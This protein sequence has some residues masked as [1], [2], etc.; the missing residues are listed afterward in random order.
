MAFCGKMIIFVPTSKTIA[1]LDFYMMSQMEEISNEY[2]VY[3]TDLAKINAAQYQGWCIHLICLAGEGSFVYNEKCFHFTSDNILILS[4]P[5]LIKNM[6]VTDDMQVEYLAAP[7]RWLYSQ[8][9]A[10]HYGIGGCIDL[11]SDP[12]VPVSHQEAQRFLGDIH[13]ICERINDTDHRFYR[14]LMGSLALTMVYDLFNVHAQRNAN[15]VSTDR[16]A[17]VVSALMQLLETGI[18]RTEREV[19]YYAKQLHVSPKYL[20]NTIKRVTGNS[21]RYLIDQY[22]I[23]IVV[24]YLKD[25]RY[26][27]TQ[28]ADL[29]NFGSLSYFSRY[30]TKHL[31]MSPSEYRKSLT[32]K[33]S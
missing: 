13:H 5:E 17:Y 6:A 2:F 21:V 26:A 31:G 30:C 22:T 29:M 18:S 23:P 1:L 15:T 10:N 24:D 32:P 27:I 19:A 3:S 11:L 9:P 25:N 7:L 14:E 20:S 8:L 12:V 4:H 33:D 28:I 16:T